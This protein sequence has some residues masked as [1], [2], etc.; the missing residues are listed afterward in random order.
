V[1][2]RFIVSADAVSQRLSGINDVF[3]HY[4]SAACDALARAASNTVLV[5]EMIQT[6]AA[7]S[8]N[9]FAGRVFGLLGTKAS[10]TDC[11]LVHS[12]IQRVL[13][14]RT[15]EGVLPYPLLGRAPIEEDPAGER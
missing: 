11:E 15:G 7:K 8:A 12:D 4:P 13:R 2:A 10:S 9:E 6:T 5:V 1:R 3:D 14:Q